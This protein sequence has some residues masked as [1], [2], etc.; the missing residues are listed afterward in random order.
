MLRGKIIATPIYTG[1][2]KCFQSILTFQPQG[3]K[4]QGQN[5]LNQSEE[6]KSQSTLKFTTR[7][8]GLEKTTETKKVF[9]FK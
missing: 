1:K 8:E 5:K 3:L 4:S 9:L 2:Q 6:R 7:K